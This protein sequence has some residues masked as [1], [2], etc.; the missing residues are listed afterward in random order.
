MKPIYP[1]F[2]SVLSLSVLVSA[3][4]AA[5]RNY[6]NPS[7]D[8]RQED[9]AHTKIEGAIDMIG[10]V[11]DQAFADIAQ[12]LTDLPLSNHKQIIPR[13]PPT[14]ASSVGG[15]FVDGVRGIELDA[16]CSVDQIKVI[17]DAWHNANL[18]ATEAATVSNDAS[19]NY[20]RSG[21]N[22]KDRN[23]WLLQ[24]WPAFVKMLSFTKTKSQAAN[25]ARTATYFKTIL[26]NVNDDNGPKRKTI[27]PPGSRKLRLVCNPGLQY[28]ENS[29]ELSVCGGGTIAVTLKPKITWGA[30]AGTDYRNVESHLMV[31]CGPFFKLESN[32]DLEKKLADA[33]SDSCNIGKLRSTAEIIYHEWTHL[34][35]TLNLGGGPKDKT[36]WESIRDLNQNGY[37]YASKNPDNLA[38][39]A[40][41]TR[42]AGFKL[43]TDCDLWKN[44]PDLPP[45]FI[46]PAPSPP[47]TPPPHVGNKKVDVGVS[48]EKEESKHP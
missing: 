36:N 19:D 18:M 12:N 21:K 10:H 17:A 22:D 43:C 31:F 29:Q 1:Y 6:E 2:L 26:D 30:G 34:P 44:Y 7:L 41:W 37:R 15:Q 9:F 38:F 3:G 47:S 14:G 11:S 20:K 4:L 5:P 42:W 48:N 23:V 40:V 27:S 33:T 24:K 32:T 46:D 13:T 25:L 16:S 28:L 39:C 45:G 35:W 8:A